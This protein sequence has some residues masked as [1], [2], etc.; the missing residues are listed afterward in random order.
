M[1]DPLRAS[2][3]SAKSGEDEEHLAEIVA[4]GA[5]DEHAWRT[6]PARQPAV[7][8]PASAAATSVPAM[9]SSNAGGGAGSERAARGRIRAR[10]VP[11]NNTAPP[12][13]CDIT[14]AP[15]VPED[16]PE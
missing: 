4:N 13:Y 5:G 8:T 12:G 11:L 15:E 7:I 3:A 10:R 14:H 6:T 16:L 1:P 2:P 9:I